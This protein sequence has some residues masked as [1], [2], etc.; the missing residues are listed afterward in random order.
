MNRKREIPEVFKEVINNKEVVIFNPSTE[1]ID[2]QK[3]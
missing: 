1:Q 2:L 3:N